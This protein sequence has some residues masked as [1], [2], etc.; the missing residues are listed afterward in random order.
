MLKLTAIKT[1]SIDVAHSQM[2]VSSY[3]DTLVYHPNV[4]V[5]YYLIMVLTSE[6]V[7]SLVNMKYKIEEEY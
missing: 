4:N 5:K 7:I 6:V 1:K 2:W 3:K